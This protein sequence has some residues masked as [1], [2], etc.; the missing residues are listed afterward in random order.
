LPLLYTLDLVARRYKIAPWQI[1]PDDPHVLM[2]LRRIWIFMDMEEQKKQ[3]IAKREAK[4][5]TRI[6]LP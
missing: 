4:P 6:G 5:R 2:H 1:D 3:A